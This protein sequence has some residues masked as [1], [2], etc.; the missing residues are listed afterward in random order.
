MHILSWDVCRCRDTYFQL[1][2]TFLL[3]IKTNNTPGLH[4]CLRDARN[5]EIWIWEHVSYRTGYRQA[6]F[7]L[8][9]QRANR[10]IK[11]EINQLRTSL[12]KSSR[13]IGQRGRHYGVDDTANCG[14]IC[15]HYV[16]IHMMA[17]IPSI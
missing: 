14:G 15:Q 8:W 11:F 13:I 16:G 1:H 3:Q 17:I 10:K 5:K 6:W 7:G 2:F 4:S 12:G 9:T